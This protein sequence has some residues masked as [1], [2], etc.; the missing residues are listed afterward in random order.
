MT[1]PNKNTGKDSG[2]TLLE[3]LIV[4]LVMGLIMAVLA[5]YGPPKSH[6]LETKA[7]ARGV[8][9]AMVTARGQ[10][11]TSGEAVTVSL[12][13]V[14]N[15]LGETVSGPITF[16]PDGSSSGGTVVLDDNGRELTVTADWLTG[17]ARLSGQ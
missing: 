1:S 12:P 16:E 7:A 17:Q 2:F 6:W 15:W 13:K 10:A 4:I 14:P 3:M 5:G 11:I 9:A 8:A